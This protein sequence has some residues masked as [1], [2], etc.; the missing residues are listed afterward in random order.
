LLDTQKGHK[1][2][3]DVFDEDSCSKDDFLGHV[4]LNIT[5]LPQ[6][7][8]VIES[9]ELLD[10]EWENS[11]HNPIQVSGQITIELYFLPLKLEVLENPTFQVLSIFVYS[12]N[13]LIQDL[14]TNIYPTT[15]YKHI[16]KRVSKAVSKQNVF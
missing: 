1:L 15:R 4:I 5:D 10:D 3:I 6:N 2:R 9:L 16:L 11:T 13:N 7:E 14:E 12:C 8:P